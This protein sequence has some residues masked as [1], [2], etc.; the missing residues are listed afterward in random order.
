MSCSDAAPAVR[1]LT[2][3]GPSGAGKGTVARR[4]AAHFG[5]HLL[6][7]GALYRL[8]ALAARRADVPLSDVEALVHLVD[9]VAMR[10]ESTPEG[11]EKILLENDVVTSEIR[12]ETCGER[13]SIVAAIP[14]VRQAL[15]AKQREF[16]QAPGLVA[17]GRDMCTVIFPE[18]AVKVFLTASAHERA[19]R[20]H[21]QLRQKGIGGTFAALYEDIRRRDARDAGR[22]VAPLV[23]AEDATE[24]DTTSLN[25]DEVVAIIVELTGKS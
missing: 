18:A 21:N 17:D 3:D 6:D 13:A 10:F 14:E 1:I 5:W 20:R 7:S 25:I 11:E 15:V 23:P 24:V 12:E 9:T 16:A 2:I 8:T 19:K 22:A 4:V